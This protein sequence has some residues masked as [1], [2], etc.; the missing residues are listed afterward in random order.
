V[1]AAIKELNYIPNLIAKQ[2]SSGRTFNIAVTLPYLTYPSFV[3]RLRGVQHA[4]ADSDYE[5]LLYGAETS[6]RRDRNFTALSRTTLTDGVL[7]VSVPLEKSHAE[8]FLTSG[9]PVV[10]VDIYHKDF[11]RVFVDDQV[12]GR[13]AT[14]HLI[15][16]GHSKIAYISDS[17]K[18]DYKFLAARERYIGYQQALKEAGLPPQDHYHREA[19]HGRFEAR[20]LA[21]E[22]LSIEDPPSAIFAGSDTQA[23]GVLDAAQDLG[24]RV[25][26]DLSVI[27]YDGIRDAEYLGLTTIEQPLF[28]SGVEGINLLIQI[29]E[30]KPGEIQQISMPLNLVQRKTTTAFQPK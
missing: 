7:I 27:G 23:I 18:A 4:L 19:P 3:E 28:D 14:Q 11:H 25:P 24:M 2:L 10:L 8:D 12:G 5:L 15:D 9:I 21:K 22:L 1:L 29:I 30:N 26:E 17:L 6:D 16:L 13:M 20:E